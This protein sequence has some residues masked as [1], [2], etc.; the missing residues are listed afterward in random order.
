MLRSIAK[1][2]ELVR[3][4][5]RNPCPWRIFNFLQSTIYKQPYQVLLW[6]LGHEG[7]KFN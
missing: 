4:S 5:L 3:F 6:A 2:C 7:P 1:R